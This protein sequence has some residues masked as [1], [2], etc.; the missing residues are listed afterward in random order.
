MY[1]GQGFCGDLAQ[2]PTFLN[3]TYTTKF[4]DTTPDYHIYA[5]AAVRNQPYAAQKVPSTVCV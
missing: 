3:N 5:T 1:K 4:I 2:H